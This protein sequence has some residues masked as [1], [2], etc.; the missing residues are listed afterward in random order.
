MGFWKKKIYANNIFLY[1]NVFFK[2]FLYA[3]N[4][5]LLYVNGFLKKGLIAFLEP[6]NRP[7]G[8]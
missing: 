4:T 3:N 2:G 7:P 1:V 5:F 8:D 6:K